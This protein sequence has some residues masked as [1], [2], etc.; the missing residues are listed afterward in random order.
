ME[1]KVLEVYNLLLSTFKE[2]GWWPRF[3]KKENKF[4]YDEGFKSSKPDKEEAFIIS[5]SA[6][7]AQ[8]INWKNVE[9][10]VINLN[11]ENLLS[12]EALINVDINKLAELIKHAGYFNQKAKKIKKFLEFN[13]E[14]SRESL[15]EVWG[16]GDETAD[17]ILLYAY[18]FPIF[19]IDAYTK[20]IFNRIG[21]KLK[22][23]KE[24]QELFH[25]YLP[26]DYKLFNEY[27]ALLV[28]LAKKNCK[29]IPICDNCPL[30]KVCKKLI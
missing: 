17:S 27:H 24:F 13:K 8:N 29:K 10:S 20:R 9:K 23:Y 2:Q 4:V 26:K 16:I 30:N 15:L 21:F 12:K 28:E 1:N 22:S 11:K 3:N 6:I 19:V 18:N 7:L 25:K 5:L 14:L